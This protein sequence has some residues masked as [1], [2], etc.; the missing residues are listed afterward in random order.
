M[1]DTNSSKRVL[2][3]FYLTTMG[4]AAIFSLRN[5]PITAVY[6]LSSVTYYIA[7]A[8]L[9]FIPTALV[10]S[11]L[12]TT[13]PQAGGLYAWVKQ[14]LGPNFGFLAIWFE[15]INTVCSFP[16]MLGFILF[17]L[18]YP[19]A[20]GIANN[21]FYEFGFMVAIFWFLTILNFFGIKTSSRFSAAGV[22]LGTL[23]IAALIITLGVIWL[24]TG[25]PSQ[26]HFTAH[27]LIPT[28]Q[29]GTLAFLITMINSVSGIQVIAFHSQ[30]TQCPRRNYPR[31]AFFIVGLILVLSILGTLSIA[32]VT[33]A[34]SGSLIGGIVKSLTTFLGAFHLAWLVPMLV[35]LIAFGVIAE[36]NAWVIGPSKGM[37]AAAEAGQLPK[38]FARKNKHG[39]PTTI[40]LTQGI[41]GTLLA[42]AYIYMPS[43]N[44]AYWLLSDLTAEFT[45][46]MWILVFIS[47]I[48]LY[49]K[50]P[51]QDGHYKIPGGIIGL[52]LTASVGILVCIT[53]LIFSYIPPINVIH[54][55]SVMKYEIVLLGGLILFSILP[56]LTT[57]FKSRKPT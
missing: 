28:F 43:V 6:G 54:S 7:A 56:L 55:N 10:C 15:W 49:Y 35:L 53:V 12:T 25:H 13:W 34:H 14:A 4:I 36:I 18:I 17:T 22:I 19:Y 57:I 32:V 40:L 47:V 37:L 26:I 33:P 44:S 27:A 5:L 9:F 23:L 52:W 41:I 21:R 29:L 11:Q 16:M 46:M 38:I 51:P 8:I 1:N 31:A 50:H 48:V 45:V 2:G 20:H 24:S 3:I 30:E 42:C 39:V